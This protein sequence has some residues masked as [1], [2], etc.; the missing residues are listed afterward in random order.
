MKPKNKPKAKSKPKPQPKSKVKPRTKQAL[1]HEIEELKS[2]LEEQEETLRAIREGEVDALM[3]S[4]PEG[5]KVYTLKGAEQ[6]YRIFIET[7]HEG[8]LMLS[9]AGMI[10]YANTRFAE[11]V[12]MPLESIINFPLDR[13]MPASDRANFKT[14]LE[15]GMRDQASGEISLCRGRGQ[16]LAARISVTPFEVEGAPCVS[17]VVTDISETK[18][19]LEIIEAGRLAQTVIEQSS[20]CIVVCDTQGMI[21]AAAAAAAAYT[22]IIPG[23]YCQRSWMTCCRSAIPAPAAAEARCFP[24]LKYCGASAS[25]MKKSHS[26][27]APERGS[28][29]C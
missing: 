21:H 24:L 5:E 26:R 19:Y 29:F 4:T 14:L 11:M 22:V 27:K 17:A 10:L 23:A 25:A 13:Y 15:D 28:I 12:S 9:P 20:D 3:V 6:V 7:M 8:A 16:Y 18:E 2:R 1:L